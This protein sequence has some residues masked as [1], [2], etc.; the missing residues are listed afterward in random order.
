MASLFGTEDL[1]ALSEHL[2]KAAITV[3]GTTVNGFFDQTDEEVLR[4]DGAM[5]TI[6]RYFAR[7]RTGALP[8]LSVGAAVTVDGDTFA[9]RSF[10]RIQD[11]DFTEI[12]LD[13]A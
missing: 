8:G 11:G 7:V 9:V 2:G 3:D 1:D 6:P 5:L 12:V 10:R 4:G 13:T